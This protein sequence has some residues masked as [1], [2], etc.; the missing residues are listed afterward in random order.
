M[1]SQSKSSKLFC[2][3]QQID[4]KV[5]TER[6]KTQTRQLII[7]GEEQSWEPDTVQ[8]PDLLY[9]YKN[10]DS[11]VLAK[12]QTNRPVEQSRKPRNKPT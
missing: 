7:E 12:E 10:Q 1:Q 5:Y 2:G 8:L 11:V 3:Y 9:S 6:Q 4:C